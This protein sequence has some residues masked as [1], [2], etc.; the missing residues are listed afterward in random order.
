MNLDFDYYRRINGMDDVPDD[1]GTPLTTERIERMSRYLKNSKGDIIHSFDLYKRQGMLTQATQLRY[2][3]VSQ[4]DLHIFYKKVKE[5]TLNSLVRGVYADLNTLKTGDYITYADEHSGVVETYMVRN[6]PEPKRTYEEAY[7]DGD[8]AFTRIE[9]NKKDTPNIM[10]VG[11]SFTNIMEALA[12]K[13]SI[14]THI[15]AKNTHE[16]RIG[17]DIW[18]ACHY[19]SH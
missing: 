2:K 6:K 11:S 16:K 18:H 4:I 9:T 12:K 3:T 10:F 13:S 14:S 1:N 15:Y 8:K 7:M 19:R 5:P 17:N